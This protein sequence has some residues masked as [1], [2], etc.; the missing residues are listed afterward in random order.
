MRAAV[1]TGVL[2][3]SHKMVAAGK[4]IIVMLDYRSGQTQ[5]ISDEIKNKIQ[6]LQGA[7]VSLL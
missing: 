3:R 7:V 5:P 2:L 1:Y 6:R 4:G